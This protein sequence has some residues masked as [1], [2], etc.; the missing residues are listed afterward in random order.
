MV[1]GWR[2]LGNGW[3][4]VGLAVLMLAVLLPGLQTT[5]MRGSDA[6]GYFCYLPALFAGH[7]FDFDPYLTAMAW[8]IPDLHNYPATGRMVNPWTIGPALTWL[9]AYALTRLAFPRAPLDGLPYW[10]ACALTSVAVVVAGMLLLFF[11]LLTIVPRWVAAAAAWAGVLC[12]PVLAYA[13]AVPFYSHHLGFALCSFMLWVVLTGRTSRWWA[14]P[15]LGMTV[16]LLADTRPQH[17]ILALLPL[18]L[19]PPRLR[20]LPLSA[21]GFLVVFFPQMLYWRVTFGDW[22]VNTYAR[23]VPGFFHVPAWWQI[24]WSSHHGLFPWHPVLLLAA[25]GLVAALW[26]PRLRRLAAVCLVLFVIDSAVSASAIDWWACWSFG[27]R[28]FCGV[29]PLLM[30][31][32]AVVLARRPWLLPVLLAAAWWNH[33]LLW[34]WWVN[35][36]RVPFGEMIRVTMLG[37]PLYPVA[38]L[39]VL[40]ALAVTFHR[41]LREVFGRGQE[42]EQPESDLAGA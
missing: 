40:L 36:D 11:A 21:L 35:A 30:V 38:V 12:T 29:A 13:S 16:G 33:A 28:R 15:V 10:T 4:A 39:T 1:G 34:G 5:P 42:A 26:T 3:V 14:W 41:Q 18:A 32:L 19:A 23:L 2:H 6:T 22:L 8:P 7:P 17:V 9:P 31:G 25:G 20:Q 24:W 27:A 37:Y